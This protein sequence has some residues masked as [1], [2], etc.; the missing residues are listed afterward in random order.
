MQNA[1]NGAVKK[2]LQ[3]KPF[4]QKLPTTQLPF[5]TG[6]EFNKQSLLNDRL[7]LSIT[8]QQTAQ[9]ELLLHIPS[10]IPTET[11]AAPA[12][13]KQVNMNIIASCYHRS[14]AVITNTFESAL[15]ISYNNIFFP[16]QQIQ[17]PFATVEHTTIL[18]AVALQYVTTKKETLVQD[19]RWLPCSIVC[20]LVG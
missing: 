13:T 17:L 19:L 9:Q 18:V 11:I 10:F 1:F 5:V 15:T 3:T 12:Y 6:F 8:L 16:A 2:W 14:K 20:G 7:H 4:E